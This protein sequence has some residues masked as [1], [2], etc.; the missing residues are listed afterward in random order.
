MISLNIVNKNNLKFYGHIDQQ[1]RIIPL[2]NT[3]YEILAKVHKNQ[4]VRIEIVQ[5]RNYEFHK[6]FFALLQLGFSNQDQ[7]DIFE[8]YRAVFIM[9]CGKYEEIK[10]DKGVVY[11]PQSISFAKMSQYDFEQLYSVM[12]DVLLKEIG[13]TKREIEQ[14]LINFI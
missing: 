10:T 1:N 12:I 4:P 5:E 6:K 8:H 14:E 7:Y 2:Y 11:L 9:K 13:C 3:D